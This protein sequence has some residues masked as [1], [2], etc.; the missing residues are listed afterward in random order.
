MMTVSALATHVMPYLSS[1]G[2]SRSNA[3]FIAAFIPVCSIVGRVS[4]GWLGDIFEKRWVMAFNFI[5]MSL[6]VLAF[7]Q[8]HIYG[9]LILFLLIYPPSY[10]GATVLRGAILREYFGR[11]SFGKM[12]GIILGSASIG[13]IV[14]PTVAGWVFDTFGSYFFIWVIFSFLI[15]IMALA[16]T[17]I[18]S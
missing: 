17:Q 15:F 5:L 6:G 14:G 9:F 1:V 18:K 8:G 16:A 13:G 7:S 3:G 12:L 4:F 10:G 11:G 2:V